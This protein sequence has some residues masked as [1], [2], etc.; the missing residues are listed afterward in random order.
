MQSTTHRESSSELSAQHER[1][2]EREER[3]RERSTSDYVRARGHSAV[4]R[5]KARQGAGQPKISAARQDERSIEEQP[6][7]SA[8]RQIERARE[9]KR[10]C[11][12]EIDRVNNH[13][14]H[15][16]RP[17]ISSVGTAQ[18]TPTVAA[19]QIETATIKRFLEQFD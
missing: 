1:E 19:R 10:A 16:T 15:R 6:A 11:A 8:A 12:R 4:R 5:A 2:R 3:T 17:E 13:Q 18:R 7:I 9:S 14:S